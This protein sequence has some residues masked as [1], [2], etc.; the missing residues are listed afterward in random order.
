[1][2]RAVQGSGSHPVVGT[3]VLAGG[4]SH[5]PAL[6]EAAAVVVGWRGAN[7]M[8]LVMTQSVEAGLD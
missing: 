7:P 4:T 1:M 3:A 2:S 8:L 5:Q 6:A